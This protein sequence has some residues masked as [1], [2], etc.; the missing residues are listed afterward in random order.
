MIETKYLRG[1]YK[2]KKQMEQKF[3]LLFS[4]VFNH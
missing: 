1:D 3:G 2:E 4:V